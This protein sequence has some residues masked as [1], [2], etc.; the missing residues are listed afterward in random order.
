MRERSVAASL[1]SAVVLAVTPGAAVRAADLSGPPPGYDQGY[2]D[3]AYDNGADDNGAYDERY[4]PDDDGPPPARYARPGARYGEAPPPEAD[5]EDYDRVPP[6]PGSVKDG[7]P[8]PVSPP[9]YGDRGPPERGDR[10]ACLAPYQ[11]E[12]RLR[13]R[14]WTDIRPMGADRGLVRVEARRRDS[15]SLF[16][17]RVDRCS[18]DVVFSRPMRTFAYAPRPWHRGQR[19][20]Y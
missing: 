15:S 16:L 11:I 3:Q 13:V 7:Y 10:Y 1:V 4:A 20:G 14:G 8:V 17:L 12:H 9:R 18:G 19:W 5:D 6:P 2:D